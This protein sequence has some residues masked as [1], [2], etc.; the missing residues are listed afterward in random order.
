M[1]ELWEAFWFFLPAG[2]ANMSPVLVS[3]F[4]LL[5]NWD[6]PLDLGKKYKGKRLLGDNKTWR[7]LVCGA[8]IASLVGLF[9]YRFI[10]TNPEPLLFIILA[11]GAMGLG[12]LV[13]DAVE[14]FFKRRRGIPSGEAWIP[15]D[16][17]DYI[18]GGLV[19]VWAFVRLTL[20]EIA[21]I[22]IIYFCLHLITSY[23]GYL[24]GF[25]DKPI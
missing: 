8:I 21:M 17:I 22:F 10:A 15:Y 23:I 14:S 4:P 11:T 3:R 18:I 7:G 16:Q 12:A 24:I 25:K 20:P 6:T 2:I 1:S 13:G 5:R 9:Q 19:F